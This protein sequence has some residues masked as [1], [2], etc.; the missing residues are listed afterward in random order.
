VNPTEFDPGPPPTFATLFAT[1]PPPTAFREHFWFD[2]GPVFYRGRLDGSARLLAIASD[3]GATERVVGRTLVGDAGQRVQG[4]LAKIGLDRSYV[5]ANAFPYSF[6]PSHRNAAK[7]I[8]LDDDQLIWRNRLYDALAGQALQAIVG[9]GRYAAFAIDHWATAPP[10]VPIHKVPHPTSRSATKLL[11][12]WRS[13]VTQLRTEVA[14]DPGV[15]TNLPNF[16]SS[17]GESDYAP[18]PRRDLP[19][20]VPPSVGDDAWVR[21]GHRHS[22]V[23]RPDDHTIRWAVPRS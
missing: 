20:G 17:F 16:G 10:G 14:A 8:L 3:P 15:A 23:S 1:C 7:M 2:W 22:S 11:D 5:L 21:A 4:F 13:A 6:R 18:I 12:A 9:F 19:F